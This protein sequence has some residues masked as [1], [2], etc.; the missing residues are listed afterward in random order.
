[1]EETNAWERAYER[2]ETPREEIRKFEK[3]LAHVG[4]GTWPRS[5]RIVEIFCGRGNGLHA[6][7][8]LGFTNVEGA[9]LSPRLLAKYQGPARCH[10]CDCRALPFED[11]SRDVVIV[12]GGLH[13]LERLPDDLHTTLDEA[14]R[15]LSARGRLVVI[16]PW[17]TPFLRFV[18]AVTAR[19]SARRLSSKLDA[20][21]EMY[22]HERETYERWLASGP[23]IL[24][25]LEERFHPQR[26]EIAWGKL[27]FVGEPR[28]R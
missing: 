15:V 16:E 10:V 21:E 20:F 3:R 5:A 12:Q 4:A 7:T 1:M 13:H 17:R 11:A 22:V 26:S 23:A 28:A 6:L 8:A 18:H 19:A 2:F 25:A 14:R 27:V 24:R 9:D